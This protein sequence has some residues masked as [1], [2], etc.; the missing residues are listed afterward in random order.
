MAT[1]H[2]CF[3]KSVYQFF[4]NLIVLFGQ[5][6]ESLFVL[7]DGGGAGIP[8]PILDTPI[9]GNQILSYG[10]QLNVANLGAVRRI[11]YFVCFRYQPNPDVEK[12]HNIAG[13]AE[14]AERLNVSIRCKYVTSLRRRT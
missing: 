13:E 11:I 7:G 14:H 4:P 9:Q 6:M 1:L 8:G 12:L 10:I 5:V 2:F 3:F